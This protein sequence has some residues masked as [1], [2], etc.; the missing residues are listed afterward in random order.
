V[1]GT[2]AYHDWRR[3]AYS[4]QVIDQS[5]KVFPYLFIFG[6]E[7]RLKDGDNN[8][9][10]QPC[11][12]LGIPSDLLAWRSLKSGSDPRLSGVEHILKESAAKIPQALKQQKQ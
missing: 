5:S 3:R 1:K 10:G 12:G 8:R 7:G 6:L 11:R 9:G 4:A 2:Y